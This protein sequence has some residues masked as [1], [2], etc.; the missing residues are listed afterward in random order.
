[1]RAKVTRPPTIRYKELHLAAASAIKSFHISASSNIQNLHV[2]CPVTYL[3]FV[4]AIRLESKMQREGDLIR[5]AMLFYW[6]GANFQANGR[7]FFAA[8][9]ALGTILSYQGGDILRGGLCYFVT[10]T[11]VAETMKFMA[12]LNALGLDL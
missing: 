12:V 3:L 6:V 11:Q 8:N 10:P 4:C 2:E 7:V 1:M 5:E 9:L